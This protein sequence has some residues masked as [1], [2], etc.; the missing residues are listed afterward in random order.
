[1]ALVEVGPKNSRI[2]GDGLRFYNWM[3]Q[4]YPSVTTIRRMAGMSWNLHQWA[5]TQVVN[6]AVENNDDLARM[7]TTDD[8]LVKAAA[9]TWLRAG[10][11]E[12]RN[13]AA[14]LGKRVHAAATEGKALGK[15]DPDVVPFLRQYQNWLDDTG[16]EVLRVESQVWNLTKGYA[17][18]FDLLG[19]RKDGTIDVVD[20]KT[21]K[22][23]YPDHALQVCAYS[24]AEFVGEDNVV[25]Q[26]ATEWLHAAGA[27]SL[28]HVR[29]E[30]WSHDTVNV[31][32]DMVRAFNGLLQYAT[33]AHRN[34]DM[35]DLVIES[36]TGKA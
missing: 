13:R 35:T 27:M 7:L 24:L 28:L 33:W 10:S 11:T 12:E 31:T 34:P 30:G 25:D 15:V 18:S 14:S 6:R 29:P 1:M 5:I 21:G 26:Q 2:E 36:T 19:R 17:G 8:P 23:T 32:K 3:G 4:E 20:L 22:G 9:K 16:F